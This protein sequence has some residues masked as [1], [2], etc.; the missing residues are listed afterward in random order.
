MHRPPLS[1]L[2]CA[3]LL[4][5]LAP[6]AASALPRANPV[7]GG[8]ALVA[9]EAPGESAPQA[10]YRE[11]R[12]MVLPDA[13]APGRW[14]AVVGIAL[15]EEPGTHRVEA[16]LADGRR[17]ALEF[18]V[19]P[20][21]YASQ[22]ITL[23]DT[24]KVTPPPED[25]ARIRSETPRIKEALRHWSDAER[26]ET[27]F[28]LPV[29]GVVSGNFGLRRFYNDQPRKPHSG[30]DIAAPAGTPVRAPA[31]GTVVETGDF[32]FNGNSVF[33]DHGQGLVTMYAHMREIRVT[34]GERVRQ[35]EILGLV[36]STGR[37]TGPHL[38][39]GVSL[40]DAR[41]DPGLFLPETTAKKPE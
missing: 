16:E 39:W 15:D 4:M 36:G 33:L 26:V 38:H 24:R 10:W 20:K 28:I 5:L 21:E 23:K 11:R 18:L 40:N 29:E 30:L 2:L 14:L 19:V 13:A 9:I 35:G 7:P 1:R 3:A 31:A 27:G 32:F 25:L 22:H 17:E 8:L 41:V 34:A 6:A 12:V 37:A